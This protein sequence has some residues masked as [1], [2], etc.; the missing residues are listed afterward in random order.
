[1]NQR[2]GG[3]RDGSSVLAWAMGRMG[4]SFT[5]IGK[6]EGGKG[7]CANIRRS[8]WNKINWRGAVEENS[9]HKALE[10]R[11]DVSVG[12]PTEKPFLKS[13]REESRRKDTE[14]QGLSPG[15]GRGRQP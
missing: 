3:V 2:E 8:G 5:R 15:Q 9:G 4:L 13:A 10:L 12:S 11:G 1:M 14:N 7:Y 6:V